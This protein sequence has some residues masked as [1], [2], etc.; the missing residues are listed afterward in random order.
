LS[1]TLFF[2]PASFPTWYFEGE[3]QALEAQAEV[4]YDEA[5]LV[6]D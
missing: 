6:I 1:I 5:A 3:I 2:H 4:V